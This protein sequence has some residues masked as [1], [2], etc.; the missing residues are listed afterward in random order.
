MARRL[1][2]L[3]DAVRRRLRQPGAIE[4]T[5]LTLAGITG[6]LTGTAVWVLISLVALVQDLV[7]ATEVPAWQLVAVPTLGGLVVGVLVAG[8][9]PRPRAAAW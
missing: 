5:M 3:L 1:R 7:W 4:P 9:S 6:V 2:H 8:S